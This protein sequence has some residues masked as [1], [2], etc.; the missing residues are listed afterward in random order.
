MCIRDSDFLVAED[1]APRARRILEARNYC[2]RAIGGRSWE[3]M[4]NHPGQMTLADLYRPTPH[5]FIELHLETAIAP[6]PLLQR[7][8]RRD[9]DGLPA[10]VLD[11]VDLFL[12][13]GLHLYKHLS[14]QYTRCLLYTSRCV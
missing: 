12:G 9:F 8:D 6:D 7:L 3:F 10:P 13:Q 4:T 5:R 11:P 2:L 14:S 1:S